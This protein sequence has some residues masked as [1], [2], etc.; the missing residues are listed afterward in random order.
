MCEE[1][2]S[3][4]CENVREWSVGMIVECVRRTK[5]EGWGGVD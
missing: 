2:D 4:V 1:E 3:G 5:L